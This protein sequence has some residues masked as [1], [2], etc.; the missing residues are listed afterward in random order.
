MLSYC[1]LIGGYKLV[2]MNNR[3]LHYH[4]LSNIEGEPITGEFKFLQKA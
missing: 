4:Y 1:S 3:I 2:E